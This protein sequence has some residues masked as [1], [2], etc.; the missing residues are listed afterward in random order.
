MLRD[1][2]LAL[3]CSSE[4]PD[5][6][7]AWCKSHGPDRE[8]KVLDRGGKA[9]V[10]G[11]PL[12]LAVVLNEPDAVRTLLDFSAPAGT[13]GNAPC[14]NTS[15]VHPEHGDGPILHCCENGYCECLRLLLGRKQTKLAS[16]ETR[17]C[18][19][20]AGGRWGVSGEK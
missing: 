10:H 15:Y 18:K 14:V 12:Y 2:Q 6:L 3:T 19:V 13:G 16:I 11:T 17:D 20:R 7:V 5:R 8:V 4:G 9:V 1:L